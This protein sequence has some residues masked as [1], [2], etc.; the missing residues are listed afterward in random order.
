MN[1]KLSGDAALGMPR[2]DIIYCDYPETPR[3]GAIEVFVGGVA[4]GNISTR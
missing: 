4:C 2:Y 1:K 3:K